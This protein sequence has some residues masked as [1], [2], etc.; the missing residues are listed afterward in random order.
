MKCSWK[1]ILVLG[2]IGYFPSQS[3]S[4]IPA[5]PGAEGFGAH[6]IGGRGGR[7]IEVTNLNDSGPGSFRAACEA[8]G[9]RIVVF[10][11]GGTI[12]AQSDIPISDPYLTIAG[13]TAPGDGICL[14]GVTLI[15]GTHDVIVR[16]LRTR[17]GDDRNG[18][19]PE[20]RDGIR[21]S[22]PGRVPQNVI[23]DHCSV[24]WGIDENVSSDDLCI[25]VTVQWC[26]ISEGLRNSIHPQGQHSAGS[27]F[28]PQANRFSIHHNLYAHN[29]RRNPRTSVDDR[30]DVE[31]INNVVYNWT[32][33]P[34][35]IGSDAHVIANHYIPGINWDQ[36]V[37]GINV[38]NANG[39][40]VFVK[41][42]I[43]PGRETNMGDDWLIVTG[44]EQFRVD[45]LVF[46]PSGIS[47]DP[48]EEVQELVLANAGAVV[49]ARDPVDTRVVQSVR[50]RSGSQ[51]D[52]QNKVG[53]WP[54]LAPGVPPTDSD[55]DGMPDEWENA[56]GLDPNDPIDGN[57]DFNGDGYTNIEKYINEL[58]LVPGT[59][60]LPDRITLLTPKDQT[61][62]KD[63][64]ITF[65]WNRSIPEV[66]RYWFEL[67]TDS[68]LTASTVD[69]TV[70]DTFKIVKE[71]QGRTTLWWRVRAKNTAGW[72]PFSEVRKLEVLITGVDETPAVPEVF[73]L[74]QNYP[75]PFNPTTTIAFDIPRQTNVSLKIF[76]LTGAEV[77]T[78]LNEELPAG[79]HGVMV[80]GRHLASGVY[81]YRLTADGMTA[82]KKFVLLR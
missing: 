74:H 48:V 6:A 23:I 79:G 17:V 59:L 53:G 4:Q 16:G 45:T 41:N 21:I 37:N 56:R 55:R 63:D 27:K 50:N 52:S 80:D 51:I 26:I 72:G 75:N 65:S 29:Y 49:P 69:S 36:S 33:R 10:R 14:R 20:S 42:N 54:E 31:V 39:I 3:L 18:S 11:T 64:S 57:G 77:M 58:L 70:T 25:D 30:S 76:N 68:L 67:G 34:T 15:I 66:S 47:V 24:S 78:V 40:S 81:F 61:L 71:I 46:A 28:G 60:P 2:F 19:S 32:N 13:Q 73:R 12:V 35:D 82:T 1:L 9:P 44:S 5:F 38:R 22:S 7:V 8:S 43:G 62:I